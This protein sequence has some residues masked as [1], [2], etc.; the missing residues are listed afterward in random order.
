MHAKGRGVP[1]GDAEAAARWYRKA[2][3]QGHASAQFN[4]GSMYER[5]RGVPQDD[6][7]A[8]KWYRRRVWV[9]SSKHSSQPTRTSNVSAVMLLT[10]RFVSSVNR[11]AGWISSTAAKVW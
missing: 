11:S 10:T 5:G 6:A 3:D 2:A 8:L 9:S 7:A 4:L 1:Q